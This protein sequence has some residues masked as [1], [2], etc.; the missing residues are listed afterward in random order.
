MFCPY[1]NKWI[2][3]KED[4]DKHFP[5][6]KIAHNGVRYERSQIPEGVSEEEQKG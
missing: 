4:C 1:C 5:E 6:C 2:H 3:A